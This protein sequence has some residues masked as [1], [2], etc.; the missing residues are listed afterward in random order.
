MK[1]TACI[2]IIFFTFCLLQCGFADANPFAVEAR[3]SAFS[4]NGE[5]ISFDVNEAGEAL[6]CV[7]ELRSGQTYISIF[8][9]QGDV[10]CSLYVETANG[11]YLCAAF[12]NERNI[13]LHPNRGD[14]TFILDQ[15]GK[16][17]NS[18]EDDSYNGALER[19][20]KIH[21]QDVIFTRD[22]FHS[23]ITISTNQEERIFYETGVGKRRKW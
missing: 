11:E 9:L 7:Q 14:I 13:M 1:K 22:F 4:G 18:Y 5:I 23:K 15:H 3:A 12:E 16:I 19:K 6:I 8:N 20:D 21:Y 10:L 2:A 17:R